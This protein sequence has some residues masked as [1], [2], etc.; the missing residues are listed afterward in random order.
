MSTQVLATKLY[1]PPTNPVFVPRPRLN[2]LLDEGLER[3]LTLIS[4]PPGYG[5]TTLLS[6]WIAGWR[7]RVVPQRLPQF[8]WLS[9]DAGDNDLSRFLAYLIAA[10]QTVSPSTGQSALSILQRHK[11]PE[12]E[13][14]I[15]ALLNDLIASQG[16]TILVLDDFSMIQ[17]DAVHH[18]LADFIERMPPQ[19]NL[20]I[21]TRVD[22][23]LPLARLRVCSQLSEV[24]A[25]DLR[26]SLAE[27][28][29]LLKTSM[30]LE[31]TETDIESLVRRTEGWVA[32]LQM[33]G[34][35]LQSQADAAAFI[36]SFTGSNRY[37]FDYLV[38]EVLARQPPD[39]REFLLITSVLDHLSAPLCEA[40]LS[41]PPV[42]P[43]VGQRSA[44]EI[45]GY[46]ERA[47]LFVIPLDSERRWYRY[48]HLFSD[49]LRLSLQQVW[50]DHIP[51]LHLRASQW[52]EKQGVVTEAIQHALAGDDVARVARLVAGNVLAL[53][54]HGELS[55][56]LRQLQGLPEQESHCTPW[57]CIARAWAMAYAGQT[58][59]VEPLLRGVE[60]DLSEQE[61]TLSIQALSGHIA[62]IRA[63]AEWIQG[64]FDG[65]IELAQR[66]DGLLLEDEPVARALNLTTLGTS[67]MYSGKLR[68]T[69]R[70]LAQA[71]RLSQDAAETHVTLLAGASLAYVQ[72]LLGELHQAYQVC[73]DLLELA[74][75][76][77]RRSGLLMP[78]AGGISTIQS[79]IYLEWN[80]LPAAL[81]TAR[82]GLI[83]AQQWGQ[84]DNLAVAYMYLSRV[85]RAQGDTVAALEA[86]AQS[87]QVAG[88]VSLWFHDQV[89]S[90]QA[91][92]CLALGELEQTAEWSLERRLNPDDELVYAQEGDYRLLAWL[93]IKQ[94]RAEHA[95]PL[96]E[97]VLGVLQPAEAVRAMISTY[98]LQ[99]LA[100]HALNQPDRALT[101]LD[102]AITLA[103]PGGFVRIF[104]DRGEII[105]SL[106]G[107]LMT[108]PR[109]PKQPRKK[110]Y[111]GRVAAA[112]P[113]AVPDEALPGTA[114]TQVT[115]QPGPTNVAATGQ[116]AMATAISE[117]EMEVLRY[118]AGYLSVPEIA[119]M[120]YVSPHTI[121]SHVKSIY[122][123]LNAHNRS[124]AVQRARELGLL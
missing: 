20:V 66:A 1:I 118:L 3:K 115:S 38:E 101:A 54:E 18:L 58:M 83:L 87:G 69:A 65:A 111:L 105:Q 32:G 112:F 24:R 55:V 123:K 4:A 106:L 31:L 100:W 98:I 117:R 17:D 49:L 104:V 22:P 90:A 39:I 19:I 44:A 27:A 35:S 84:V 97:K 85:L 88:H 68:Q 9:L 116:E 71:V 57:L 64:N 94:G 121:R 67:L 48:H 47:N 107:E 91:E 30:C 41:G 72:L 76:Y 25:E 70:V 103:E 113:D 120:L 61:P 14:I 78:A 62:A 37:I 79:A 23:I 102:Q 12:V 43:A 46:L 92:L 34:L 63:Y 89:G 95:L 36:S 75:Q 45:L 2:K 122:G 82:Q 53:V 124:Q 5:K 108:E 7:I 6:A 15:S 59:A 99:A 42:T 96:L 93:L 26:F 81:S 110:K 114:E 119:S 56:L 86:M 28:S 16:K 10:I 50:G 73:Q 109:L 52:Y 60:N 8:C 40:V 13:A 51:A 80:D 11:P 77:A 74:M 29:D 21:A 33:A